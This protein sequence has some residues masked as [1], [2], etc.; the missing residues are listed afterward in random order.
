VGSKTQSRLVFLGAAIVFVGL[1]VGSSL[2][3][4]PHDVHGAET[5]PGVALGWRLLFHIERASAV[6]GAT[7]TALLIAWRGA[8]GEWPIK[9]GNLEY[10]PKE[11]VEVTADMISALNERLNGQNIRLEEVEGRVEESLGTRG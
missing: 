5:L 4:T 3:G 1:V 11:T 2:A 6:L 7:G 9:F 8:H 10:A